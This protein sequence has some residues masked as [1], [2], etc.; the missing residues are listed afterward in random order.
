MTTRKRLG[1]TLGLEKQSKLLGSSVLLLEG[2]DE[3][4][5]RMIAAI[6][7]GVV[8]ACRFSAFV[9]G[10]QILLDLGTWKNNL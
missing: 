8:V 3:S 5:G 7:D 1:W 2:A 10:V 4:G 6:V 9:Q